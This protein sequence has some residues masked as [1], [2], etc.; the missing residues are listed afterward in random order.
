MDKELQ[1]QAE[2]IEKIQAA[3]NLTLII[4]TLR[5]QHPTMPDHKRLD[6]IYRLADFFGTDPIADFSL[7]FAYLEEDEEPYLE[8]YQITLTFRPDYGS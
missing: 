6:L 3:H 2:S 4:H 8:P 1:A 5:E 7:E